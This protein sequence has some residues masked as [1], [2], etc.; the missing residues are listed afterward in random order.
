MAELL[1]AGLDLGGLCLCYVTI[2]LL[3]LAAGIVD[4]IAK[5]VPNPSIAGV[6]PLGFVPGFVGAVQSAIQDALSG[7]DDAAAKF[8][9]GLLDSLTLMIGLTLLLGLGVYDLMVLLWKHSLPAYI[10]SLLS[11][12]A[13]DAVHAVTSV[14][15]L[16]QT[17]ADNLAKAKSYADGAA[18]SALATAKAYS[19]TN[20]L[21]AATSLESDIKTLATSTASGIVAADLAANSAIS[22]AIRDAIN[23][24][25]Y[26]TSGEL[27]GDVVDAIHSSGALASAIASVVPAVGGL[28]SSQVTSII[29]AALSPGGALVGEIESL[30]PKGAVSGGLS[31]S[32]VAGDI[33]SA[34]QDALNPGGAIAAAIADA[35]PV[36]IPGVPSIPVPSLGDLAT[37]VAGIGVAVAGIEAISFIGGESC[38]SNVS[39]LCGVNGNDLAGLLG[40]LAAFGALFSL[41][42]LAKAAEALAGD[43]ADVLQQAA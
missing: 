41:A 4:L 9:S 12:P 35:I 21:A 2:A 23:A 37:T 31:A 10:A 24:A 34:I 38:R 8:Q 11:K 39:Q 18:A 26:I 25:G 16:E 29:G 22:K 3:L 5:L 17:V 33:A 7:V 30:I 15:T 42:D 28:T 14:A 43:V 13:A 40:G 6:H 20:L 32:D 27:A 1:E 36:S 19:T